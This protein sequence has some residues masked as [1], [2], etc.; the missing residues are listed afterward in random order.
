MDT[1]TVTDKDE[2]IGLV[3]KYLQESSFCD[4]TAIVADNCPDTHQVT[5]YVRDIAHRMRKTNKYEFKEGGEGYALRYYIY[6]VP[7]KPMVEKYW[8]LVSLGTLIVGATLSTVNDI[9]K[10]KILPSPTPI[11]QTVLLQTDLSKSLDTMKKQIEFLKT[12]V[13]SLN[14]R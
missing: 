2:V 14:N 5:S 9:V 13:D 10:Q 7:R 11:S 3:K 4:L 12:Q 1:R 8:Y 6:E